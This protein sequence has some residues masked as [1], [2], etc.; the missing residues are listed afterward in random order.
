MLIEQPIVI[1]F[2]CNVSAEFVSGRPGLGVHLVKNLQC[3]FVIP[4]DQGVEANFALVDFSDGLR[5][6]DEPEKVGESEMEQQ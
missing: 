4:D 1:V 2:H 5:G 3:F 6:Q